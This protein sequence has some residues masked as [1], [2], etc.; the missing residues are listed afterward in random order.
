[1]KLS[2]GIESAIHC[3]VILAALE[4]GAV[5][6]AKA[7]AEYHGVSES[8]LL[9]QLQALCRAGL[10]ESVPGPAG[11]YR[12]ARS[13]EKITL[14]DFVEAIEGREPAFRCQEIRQRGP[15]GACG[16]DDAKAYAQPCSINAAMLRAETAYRNALRKE[17]LQE[18]I[19]GLPRK[20]APEKLRLGREWI[21]ANQRAAPASRL[22]T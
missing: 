11:G 10:A 16:V 5:L 9:K 18:I 7:L 12:L 1:M 17:T 4:E 3:A 20:I 14:L 19:A 22:G 8:Y 6:P 15:L 2:E 13:P 21:Q